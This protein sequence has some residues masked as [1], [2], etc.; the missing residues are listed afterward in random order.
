MLEVARECIE[1]AGETDWK[2]RSIGCYIGS[3]EED[4]VEFSAK[5][6]QQY[7]LY[8]VTGYSDFVLPNCVLH[9]MDLI[10][11]RSVRWKLTISYLRIC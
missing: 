9:D 5:D 1:D 10:G 6:N 8:R 11:P 4:W 3:Y 2:G 7:G